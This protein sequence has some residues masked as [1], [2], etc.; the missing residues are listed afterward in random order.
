M[1]LVT[2]CYRNWDKLWPDEPLGSYEDFCI[3]YIVQEDFNEKFSAII[4]NW[5]FIIA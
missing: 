1:L 3:F 2:S 5:S 4:S